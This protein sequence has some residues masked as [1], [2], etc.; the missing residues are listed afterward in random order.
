VHGI[1]CSGVIYDQ[2]KETGKVIAARMIVY[3]GEDE[4][5]FTFMSSKAWE[6]LKKWIDYRLASREAICDASWVMR[7]LWDTRLAQGR[8]FASL[9][10][11]LSALG[12]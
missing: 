11:K 7:D 10:K 6:A 2:S 4:E 3:A 9:P 8:G 5:Y 1:I 12:V